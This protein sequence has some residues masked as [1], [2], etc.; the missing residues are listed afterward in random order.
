MIKDKLTYAVEILVA[1]SD[2]PGIKCLDLSQRLGISI[3][4]TEQHI[5]D[6]R[7]NGYI[8]GLRGHHGGYWLNDG[9]TLKKIILTKLAKDLGVNDARSLHYK[10]SIEKLAVVDVF[11]VADK[12]ISSK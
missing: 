4:Y 2:T 3:S 11:K 7:E 6:L 1:I 12:I 9:V 8:M 10:D 5:A